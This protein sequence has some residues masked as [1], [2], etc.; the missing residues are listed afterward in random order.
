MS[1]FIDYYFTLASPFSWF[2]QKQLS[3]IAAK[4]G[5]KINYKPFNLMGVWEISGAV[6]P[7]ARP[8]VRQRYRLIELKRIAEMR[9]ETIIATPSNFPTNPELADRCVSAISLSGGDAG[10]FGYAVG[11]ALW[12]QDRQ[13]ADEATLKELLI[14]TGHD[15]DAILKLANDEKTARIRAQNTLDANEADAV[16]APAYVYNGEVFWGQDRLDYLDQMISSGRDA[17]TA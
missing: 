10:N 7:P 15:G 16:G 17:F 13:I 1:D 5:K 12:S 8:P 2:G 14:S 4:H 6:P 9:G 3:G 11:E